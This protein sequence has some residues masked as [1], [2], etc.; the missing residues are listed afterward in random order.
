MILVM[1]DENAIE[2]RFQI[3]PVKGQ[4]NQRQNKGVCFAVVAS[5]VE[6]RILEELWKTV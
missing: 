1:N 2:K 4:R 5:I 6:V 3:D